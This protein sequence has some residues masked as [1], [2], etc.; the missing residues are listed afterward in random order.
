M[1][2]NEIK[3]Y[4]II[5]MH[6]QVSLNDARYHQVISPQWLMTVKGSGPIYDYRYKFKIQ[7]LDRMI[8]CDSTY[9]IND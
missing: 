5:I 8:D 4:E 7:S 3:A 6:L 9:L 1:N 2:H